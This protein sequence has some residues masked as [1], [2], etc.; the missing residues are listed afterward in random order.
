M[1]APSGAVVGLGVC[2]KVVLISLSDMTLPYMIGQGLMCNGVGVSLLG[3]DGE[4]REML[5]AV[6]ARRG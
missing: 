5:D 1:K 4:G 6:W 2:R 3:Q